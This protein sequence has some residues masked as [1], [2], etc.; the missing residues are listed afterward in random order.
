MMSKIS[1]LHHGID[2]QQLVTESSEQLTGTAF[3]GQATSLLCKDLRRYSIAKIHAHDN[4]L[5]ITMVL[6]L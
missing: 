4:V 1:S 5:N 6:L 3:K 2:E